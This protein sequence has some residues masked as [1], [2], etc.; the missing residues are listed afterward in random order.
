MS[1]PDRIGLHFHPFVKDS[2]CRRLSDILQSVLDADVHFSSPQA[3]AAVADAV[4]GIR[5][6]TLTIEAIDDKDGG[7]DWSVGAYKPYI[8]RR[9]TEVDWFF[10][11][12]YAYRFLLKATGYFTNLKDPFASHKQQAIDKA[13]PLVAARL[14]LVQSAEGSIYEQF[15][16]QMILTLVANRADLSLSAGKV[17]DEVSHAVEGLL[18]VD[19]IA[20]TFEVVEKAK[21]VVVVLDNCGAE[22]FEDLLMAR[23][24]LSAFEKIVVTLHCKSHPVFVR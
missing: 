11:E 3:R 15:R 19:D 14:K 1:F 10:L 12:N 6:L 24:L 13:L 16:A 18:L 23:F 2:I 22:L 8:G 17:L 4:E 20:R 5:D 7:P 21:N 9:I